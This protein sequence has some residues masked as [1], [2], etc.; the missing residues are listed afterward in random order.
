MRKIEDGREYAARFV[1]P[2]IEMGGLDYKKRYTRYLSIVSSLK[3]QDLIV[4]LKDCFINSDSVSYP[5]HLVVISELAADGSLTDYIENYKGLI[6][7]E[8]IMNIF[9]QTLL[10]IDLLHR[11]RIFHR[12]ICTNSVLLFNKGRKAKLFGF[13]D[14]RIV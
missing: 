10:A 8:Q 5:H 9:T 6:P 13:I 2:S 7:E 12:N 3:G 11:N 14:S 4:Q 1:N